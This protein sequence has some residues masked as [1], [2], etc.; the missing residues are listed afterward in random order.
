MKTQGQV[1][2]LGSNPA[3]N[4]TLQPLDESAQNIASVSQ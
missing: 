4:R 1:N 2:A 3:V